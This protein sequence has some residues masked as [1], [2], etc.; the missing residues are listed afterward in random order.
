M[1]P[2]GPQYRESWIDRQIREATERGEF[3]NL[4]GEGKPI[5]GIDRP[6]DDNWWLKSFLEK[7]KVSMPLP[8]SL[9]LRKEVAGLQETL[10]DVRHEGHAREVVEALNERI[11]DSHRRRLDGPP[12]HLNVVDVEAAL[13]EWRQ[14]RD[15]R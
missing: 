4:P 13:T 9:Q 6:H 10:A 12:I 2:D 11:R 3:S 15:G 1:A 5:K 14:R 7:E 8:P